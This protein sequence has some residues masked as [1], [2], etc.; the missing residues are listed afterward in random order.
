MGQIVERIEDGVRFPSLAEAARWTGTHAPAISRA[1]RTGGT[2]AGYHWRYLGRRK[3]PMPT[4]QTEMTKEVALLSRWLRNGTVS[5][6]DA[7]D[8]LDTLWHRLQTNLAR[9]RNKR[10]PM[11]RTG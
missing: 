8:R 11:E 3:V 4:W 9:E 6:Q 10:I 1:I 7:A 5:Y 2:T